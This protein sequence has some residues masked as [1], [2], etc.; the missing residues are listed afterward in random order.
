MELY[1]HTYIKLLCDMDFI[2]DH[3]VLTMNMRVQCLYSLN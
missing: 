1:L 2:S 3:S